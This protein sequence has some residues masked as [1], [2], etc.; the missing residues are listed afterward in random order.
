MLF[1]LL[2]DIR[3]VAFSSANLGYALAGSNI[4]P[5]SQAFA[6]AAGG[7]LLIAGVNLA[8]SFSLALYVALRS[9]RI[10]L[11]DSPRFVSSLLRHLLKNPREFFLP[12][13]RGFVP[14]VTA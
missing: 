14:N 13:K 6:W 3:H 5:D 8:V 1:G 12:P 10:S 7:V 11:A 9:R 4:A 2:V